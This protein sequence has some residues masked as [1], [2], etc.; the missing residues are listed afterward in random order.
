MRLALEK[1]VELEN[2]VPTEEE[3]NAQIEKMANDYGVTVEQVKNAIPTEEIAKDLAVNK[4]IDLVK[5]EAVITEAKKTAAKKTTTKKADGEE[6]PA[7]KKSTAKK[8]TKKE[9]EKA[10]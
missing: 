5:A 6:K 9:E 4:A 3:I 8:T 10:E 1:I 7:A 2:I